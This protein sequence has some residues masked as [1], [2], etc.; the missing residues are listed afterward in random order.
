[1]LRKQICIRILSLQLHKRFSNGM[2]Y[3]ATSRK[4]F[5]IFHRE[6]DTVRMNGQMETLTKESGAAVFVMG[7]A[8]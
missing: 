3:S 6:K 4:D 1:M 7:R 2:S 5:F 8:Y